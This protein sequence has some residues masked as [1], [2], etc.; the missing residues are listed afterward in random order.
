M[1]QYCYLD[2]RPSSVFTSFY[3]HACVLGEGGIV[4]CNLIPHIDSYN[5]HQIG[6]IPTQ[7]PEAT[8]TWEPQ[9]SLPET[10][11][12]WVGHCLAS[13]LV[14]SSPLWHYRGHRSPHLC[15]TWPTPCPQIRWPLH[16]QRG[17][18]CPELLSCSPVQVVS[19]GQ[20]CCLQ[21]Q[22]PGMRQV[23]GNQRGW[24]GSWTLE[25]GPLR[26]GS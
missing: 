9:G 2:Y 10:Q 17:V 18:L 8:L 19:Q 24:G 12:C 21:I 7:E 3:K 20:G 4:Q 25:L 22:Q 14:P 1:I 16:L 26:A 11:A 23:T 5:H 13:S 6:S 15:I